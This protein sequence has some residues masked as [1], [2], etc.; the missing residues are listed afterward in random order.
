M[1]WSTMPADDASADPFTLE[2]FGMDFGVGEQP[3]R[4]PLCTFTPAGGALDTAELALGDVLQVGHWVREA[5]FGDRDDPH[6]GLRFALDFA[7]D[8]AAH[9]VDQ[10]FLKQMRAAADGRTADLQQV[11]VAPAI[12]KNISAHRLVH[13]F[14]FH[15]EALDSHPLGD[16]LGLRS[17]PVTLAL[18]L[19]FDFLI[20]AGK[21]LWSA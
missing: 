11:V 20:E 2:V 13:D 8:L 1:G 18:R 14:D 12:T 5:L 3:A 19:H 15:L 7:A 10:V 17:G 6:L 4:R 21:V 9:R 16:E